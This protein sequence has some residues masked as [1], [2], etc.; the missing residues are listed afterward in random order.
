[1]YLDKATQRSK[2][3]AFFL[4]YG[5]MTVRDAFEKLNINSPTKRISELRRMGYDIVGIRETRTK[6]NG[7]TVG[8]IRYYLNGLNEIPRIVEGTKVSF[9]PGFVP[10]ADWSLKRCN[11]EYLS[12]TI[13]YIN[14]EH[15]NFTVEFDCGGTKQREAFKFSQ[16]GVEVKLNG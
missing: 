14:W 6:Q 4:D 15:E 1:M 9:V 11:D 16:I 12:G 2:I 3:L 7:D 8:Y 10:F 5:S 13:T